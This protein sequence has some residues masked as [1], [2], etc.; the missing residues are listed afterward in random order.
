VQ[1]QQEHRGLQLSS[2]SS[3]FLSPNNGYSM[4]GT[5]PAHRLTHLN[6]DLKR[7]RGLS[8]GGLAAALA[9]LSSLQKLQLA[10]TCNSTPWQ[11]DAAADGE[12]IPGSC[13]LA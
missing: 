1:Q 4:L 12:A 11:L 7:S 6:L 5:L 9:R 8:G 3:N 2:F 10:S 13:L